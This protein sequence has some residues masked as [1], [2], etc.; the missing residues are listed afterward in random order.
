M[1]I[2]ASR[3]GVCAVLPDGSERVGPASHWEGRIRHF[4]SQG[5]KGMF[6]VAAPY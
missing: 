4:H 5:R 6:L 3:M 1:I 2:A